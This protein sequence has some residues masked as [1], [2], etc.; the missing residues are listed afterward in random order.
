M[1]C[2]ISSMTTLHGHTCNLSPACTCN[3]NPLSF[4]QACARNLSC[5]LACR[6]LPDVLAGN[7]H[8][9]SLDVHDNALSALPGAWA[10][11]GSSLAALPITYCDVSMNRLQVCFTGS[12]AWWGHGNTLPQCSVLAETASERAPWSWQPLRT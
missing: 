1:S 10:D 4:D 8:L 7:A 11:A 12:G 6:A 5:S 3:R 2:E 9:L